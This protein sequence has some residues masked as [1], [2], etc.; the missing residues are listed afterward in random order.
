MR[1]D[2]MKQIHQ[3]QIDYVRNSG[4]TVEVVQIHG[5]VDIQGRSGTIAF[6]QGFEGSAFLGQRRRLYHEY[7]DIS[8]SELNELLA[9][10]YADLE[11]V[12]DAEAR[13]PDCGTASIEEAIGQVCRT[14]CRGV[15]E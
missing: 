12:D 14:C 15:I 11:E 10:P 4:I 3:Q 1:T 2:K 13:C 5:T 9:Y 6:L 7:E 8:M